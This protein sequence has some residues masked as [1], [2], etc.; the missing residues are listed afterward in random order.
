MSTGSAASKREFPPL[1]QSSGNI[2]SDRLA[3][4]HILERLKTQKRTGWVNHNVPGPESI[5]DHM[6][7]MSVLAM[8]T[9]DPDLDVSKCVMMAVVHDLAEAQVGDI[10]PSDGI[11]KAE[12]RRLE[13][14]AMHNFVHEMLHNSPAAQ[15]I[16]ALWKEYEEGE[17]KEAKF[18]KD[19]DRFEMACQASEYERNHGMKTLQPFFDSSL[20][21]I[22]HPEVQAWGQALADER[23]K[24]RE[25]QSDLSSSSH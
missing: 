24:T 20:P 19:L 25:Q 6:Y 16:E 5:S 14:E 15:R 3:F 23:Q 12:K 2:S 8:C 17:T 22:K 10:A 18:V 1:Y 7:R 21:F 4:F 9:S 13:A 11:P